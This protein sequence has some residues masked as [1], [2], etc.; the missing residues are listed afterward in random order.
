MDKHI[1]SLVFKSK[2]FEVGSTNFM[3]IKRSTPIYSMIERVYLNVSASYGVHWTDLH[4]A[5][6]RQTMLFSGKIVA[7]I[8]IRSNLLY[9]YQMKQ[10]DVNGYIGNEMVEAI[11]YYFNY[12]NTK[13]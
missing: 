10:E 9:I 11:D 3:K 2:W 6:D 1:C 8:L 12:C 13:K 5:T 7:N 4:K